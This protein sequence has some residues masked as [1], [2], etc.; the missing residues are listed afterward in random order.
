MSTFLD[1]LFRAQPAT[2]LVTNTGAVVD[3][4]DADPPVAGYVLK[5]TDAEHAVWLPDSGSALPNVTNDA[6]LKRAANDFSTFSLKSAPIGT[7]LV[8]L[9]N[10]SAGGAKAYAP[11][12]S[13]QNPLISFSVPVDINPLHWW[14]GDNTVQSGGLVDTIT[15]N[16]SSPKNFTQSGAPRCPTAVDGNSRTYLAPDGSV[17]FYTAGVASDWKFLNDGSPWTVMLVFHRTALIS[18]IEFLLD[19][20]DGTTGSTGFYTLLSYT[21]ATKQGPQSAITFSSGSNLV[22]LVNSFIPNTSLQLLILRHTGWNYAVTLGTGSSVA[23]DLIMRRN[24]VLVNQCGPG[25]SV[26]A[27]VNTNPL[28]ALTLFRRS[29]TSGNFSSARL[30]DCIVDNKAWSDRQVAGAE[31]YARAQYGVVL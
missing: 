2:A 10:S 3:V 27:Y 14:R 9:E 20:T 28:S 31:A 13:L 5:A 17:D 19:T 18:A 15:D 7:D 22:Q 24:G 12:S 16:G 11:L 1:E 30:Y 4:A 21:S 26:P 23:V 8:L 25:G 6:Q 29:V